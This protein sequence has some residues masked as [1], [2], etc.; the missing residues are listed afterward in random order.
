[1]SDKRGDKVNLFLIKFKL[2][3]WT[4]LSEFLFSIEME[5]HFEQQNIFFAQKIK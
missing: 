2:P 3:K 5:F 4:S 1:M